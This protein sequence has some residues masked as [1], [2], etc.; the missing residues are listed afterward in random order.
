MIVWH[1]EKLKNYKNN[2]FKLVME[3]ISYAQVGINIMETQANFD[4]AG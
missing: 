3:G 4:I 2:S 1:L